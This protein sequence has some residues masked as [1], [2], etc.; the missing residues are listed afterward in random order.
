MESIRR[1][2]E[3]V[4]HAEVIRR[5][6]QLILRVFT[7]LANGEDPVFGLSLP[8]FI[9]FN[10]SEYAR[11]GSVGARE[12]A[13]ILQILCTSYELLLSGRT[14]TQREVYYLGATYFKD[15]KELSTSLAR[16]TKLLDV[17]RHS[18]RILAA[19]RG[20]YAGLLKIRETAAGLPAASGTSHSS[21]DAGTTYVATSVDTWDIVDDFAEPTAASDAARISAADSLSI[22]SS[23]WFEPAVSEE[24]FLNPVASAMPDQTFAH[25]VRG[26]ARNIPP[27]CLQEVQQVKNDGAQCILVVEKECVFRRLVEDRIWEKFPCIVVTGSGFPDVATRAFVWQL[28]EQLRIPVLGLCD[29]NPFGM[30]IILC[31]RNGSR[32]TPEANAFKVPIKWLGLR[33]ADLAEFRI[34]TDVRQPM[35]R[36]DMRKASSM[37]RDPYVMANARFAEEARLFIDKRFKIELEGIMAHGLGFLADVYLPRKLHSNDYV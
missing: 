4:S 25:I 8:P 14:V 24:V 3:P 17:P 35:T 2:L 34:P 11:R 10:D 20:W 21:S 16:A 5:I 6:E 22:A 36:I 29:Y 28:H 1:V 19:C 13:S 15:V 27:T 37:L 23:E 7:S 33:Y 18:L 12:L 32:S 30:A 26:P 9:S 31:Y